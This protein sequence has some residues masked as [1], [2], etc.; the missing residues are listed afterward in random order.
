MGKTLEFAVNMSMIMSGNFDQ[1]LTPALASLGK[2][3]QK[4]REL[5]RTSGQISSY[6]KQTTSLTQLEQKVTK[7]RERYES[8][9]KQISETSKPSAKH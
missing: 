8:L 7:A 1:R 4:T 2:L 3:E 6:Q 5:Q 9:G